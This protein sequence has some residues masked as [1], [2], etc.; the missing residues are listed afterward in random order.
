MS[1][2]SYTCCNKY[3]IMTETNNKKFVQSDESNEEKVSEQKQEVYDE[4]Q[5]VISQLGWS[6]SNAKIVM[7][8]ALEQVEEEVETAIDKAVKL[9]EDM[10]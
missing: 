7:E 4:L 5:E 8:E 3:S 6:I 9:L 10:D 1:L 2:I